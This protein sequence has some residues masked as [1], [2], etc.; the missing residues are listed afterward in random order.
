MKGGI[1]KKPFESIMLCGGKQCCPVVD[2][3]VASQKVTIGED[4]NT[5]T[6]KREEWNILVQKIRAGELKEW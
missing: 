1:M 2:A 4:A 3:N 5:V 6:L